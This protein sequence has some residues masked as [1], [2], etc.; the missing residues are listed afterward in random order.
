MPLVLSLFRITGNGLKPRMP[1]LA[2]PVGFLGQWH[3]KGPPAFRRCDLMIKSFIIRQA[4]LTALLEKMTAGSKFGRAWQ[5]LI[6]ASES[7]LVGWDS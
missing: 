6:K 4:G 1:G 2:V 5:A 3:C 7:G